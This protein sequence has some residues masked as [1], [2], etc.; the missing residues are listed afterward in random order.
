MD[1]GVD[2]SG[3]R[4]MATVRAGLL[5]AGTQRQSEGKEG[6]APR[7]EPW[8][9]ISRNPEAWRCSTANS[10]GAQLDMIVS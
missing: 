2:N 10:G 4:D 6:G 8:R 5:T 3:E 9:L 7:S 1:F